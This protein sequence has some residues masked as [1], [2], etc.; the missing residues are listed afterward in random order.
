[1]SLHVLPPPPMRDG[2]VVL[3]GE[4]EREI[5]DGA[6]GECVAC[7]RTCWTWWSPAPPQGF[8][9]LHRERCS[10]RLREL[11]VEALKDGDPELE[12]PAI[13]GRG[14]GAYGRRAATA[15]PRT[16]ERTVVTLSARRGIELPEGF[17]PGPFWKPGYSHLEPWTV[18]F[19]AGSG[20]GFAPFGRN[21][22][23]ARTYLRQL[24]ALRIVSYIVPVVGAVLLAPD[25]TRD[26]GWGEPPVIGEPRWEPIVRRSEWGRCAGCGRARWPGSWVTARSGRCRSCTEPGETADPRPWPA[27]PDD[28]GLAVAPEWL[29]G[30]KRPKGSGS[31]KSEV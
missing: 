28:P 12:T 18:A 9:A 17:T 29:G 21:V 6:L 31:K 2:H 5:V 3:V 26:G 20:M 19:Q 7:H 25:G 30:P 15:A 4:I 11:W 23:A 10:L 22:D 16:M 27:D 1:M 8:V 13:T 14:R 24:D